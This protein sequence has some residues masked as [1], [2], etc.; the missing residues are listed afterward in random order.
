M[1]LTQVQ[2]STAAE[3]LEFPVDSAERGELEYPHVHIETLIRLYY[4]HHNL[5]IF[6]PYLI[7]SLLTIGNHVIDMISNPTTPVD[8]AE[9][10]RSTL[11]LCARGL[12]AQGKNSYVATVVYLMLLDH[13]ERRENVLLKTYIHDELGHDQDSIRKYN[14]SNYPVP[15]IKINENPRTVLLGNLVKAYETL[16]IDGDSPASQVS[17]P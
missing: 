5:E 1:G 8:D 10:Y 13:V 2:S 6:D 16:L 9:V 15:I 12:Y 17:T 7:V 4:V 3:S 11:V 14:Q